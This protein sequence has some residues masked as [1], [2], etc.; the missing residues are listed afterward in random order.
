MTD[1]VEQV[2]VF[3][4]VLHKGKKA[5]IQ[6]NDT[7]IAWVEEARDQITQ[8]VNEC[9]SEK[10]TKQLVGTVVI[11]MYTSG[12]YSITQVFDDKVDA[13]TDDME[14]I[15]TDLIEATK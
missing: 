8:L 13:L 11:T 6:T 12:D 10:R 15:V 7:D 2:V 5:T 4:V 14:T 1:Q 9:W 3:T